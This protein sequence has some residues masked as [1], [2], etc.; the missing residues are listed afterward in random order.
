M[1]D[2]CLY[3]CGVYVSE[4]V[5]ILSSRPSIKK[6]NLWLIAASFYYCDAERQILKGF[7]KKDAPWGILNTV[8]VEHSV[9]FVSNFL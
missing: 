1:D 6:I 2:T 7:Q 8:A 9:V 4:Q 5:S 3:V